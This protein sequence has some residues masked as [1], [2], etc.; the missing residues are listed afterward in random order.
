MRMEFLMM[1]F[2]R[3]NKNRQ[4]FGLISPGVFWIILFFNLPLLIMLFI[5]FVERGRAGGIKLPPVYTIDNYRLL[6]NACSS[7]FAARSG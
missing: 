7:E 1:N 5:S 3:R 4:L 2:F 6:F